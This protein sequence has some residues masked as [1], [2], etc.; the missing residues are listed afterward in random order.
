MKV[1]QTQKVKKITDWL[2]TGSINIFG[3]PFSGKDTQ[4]RKLGQ[5]FKA[6]LIGG[7]EILRS[8][9]DTPSHVLQKVNQG[10]LA[11]T[12][13]YLK[14]VTPYLGK[15]E[16]DGRPLVLSSVGRWHGEETSIMTAAKAA[17]HPIKAVIYLV[18]DQATAFK[19]AQTSKK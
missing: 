13:E 11:P 9:E 3:W 6:S 17:N 19:R 14:I 12:D 7:G 1:T 18:L 16:F 5:L 4:G 2:G 8:R 15:K 10:D